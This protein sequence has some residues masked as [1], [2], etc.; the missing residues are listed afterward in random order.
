MSYLLPFTQ[1]DGTVKRVI[2][3]LN[4]YARIGVGCRINTCGGVSV[5]TASMYGWLCRQVYEDRRSNIKQIQSDIDAAFSILNRNRD[6]NVLAITDDTITIYSFENDNYSKQTQYIKEINDIITALE[7]SLQGLT[8]LVDTYRT[9]KEIATS[10]EEIINVIT[11]KVSDYK[12][13][14][15]KYFPV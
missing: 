13:Y 15:G 9:D 3:N 11:Q 10:L 6:S 2:D 4:I 8:N 7:N 1:E 5:Y 14:I 12:S